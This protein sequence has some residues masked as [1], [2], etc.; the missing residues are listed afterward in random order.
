[1]KLNNH[2][3][4]TLPDLARHFDFAQFWLNRRQFVRDMEPGKVYYWN[5]E[6]VEAY[7][8]V[9]TW[10]ENNLSND[11]AQREK[12]LDALNL[13]LGGSL[14]R[15]A[16]T[17]MEG[18]QMDMKQNIWVVQAGQTVDLPP[19]TGKTEGTIHL[20]LHKIE[21]SGPASES[22]TICIGGKLCATL[23]GEEVAYITELDGGC[24]EI[25]PNH[26]RNNQTDL[27]LLSQP[28]EFYSTLVVQDLFSG[29]KLMFDGVV[30]FALLDDGYI[31][32][33]RH[34]KPVYMMTHVPKF[35]LKHDGNALYVKAK[36]DT[37]VVLYEDGTLKSTTSMEAMTN[38]IFPK[39]SST[40]N[41]IT[42]HQ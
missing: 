15:S 20:R 22:T 39:I 11:K 6:L 13:L 2:L 4:V 40:G 32:I 14:D 27:S 37:V 38:V 7:H 17:L 35:M 33:D 1:M 18:C 26:Q 12:G 29:N 41:I 25:L 24:L 21:V 9:K 31:Y 10:I 3:I 28:G 8:I 42:N 30:S 16:V 34:Q 23:K 36:G 5:D 19:Y